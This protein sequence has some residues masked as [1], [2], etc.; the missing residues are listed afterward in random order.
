MILPKLPIPRRVR[1]SAKALYYGNIF[2][3]AFVFLIPSLYPE[4]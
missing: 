1:R 2:Q 3:A 4:D